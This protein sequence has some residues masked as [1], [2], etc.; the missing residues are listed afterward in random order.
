MSKKRASFSASNK[1]QCYCESG[2]S[3]E[4]CCQPMISGGQLAQTAQMLMR[5]RYTAFCLH[6]EDYLLQTWDPKTRPKRIEFETIK[7]GLDLKLLLPMLA[8]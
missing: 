8:N 3:F 1:I 7:S 6:Y 4:L 2:L 5:S